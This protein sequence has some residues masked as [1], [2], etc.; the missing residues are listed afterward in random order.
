M[1][2]LVLAIVTA[3]LVSSRVAAQ[4]VELWRGLS[5]GM[6]E[7]EANSTLPQREV[8]LFKGCRAGVDKT[9]PNG[10][11]QSVTI[12]QKTESADTVCQDAIW[13]TLLEKYGGPD[14]AFRMT[15]P[16]GSPS[17]FP[18]AYVYVWKSAERTIEYQA[19]VDDKGWSLTYRGPKVEKLV[20][21]VEGL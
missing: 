15:P 11:L 16:P 21:Y 14:H 2:I 6:T 12:S 1:R 17:S 7:G 9:F 13:K 18:N 10:K 4:G 3:T 8:D 20:P 5:V 19:Q